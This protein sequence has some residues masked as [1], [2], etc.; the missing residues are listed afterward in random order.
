MREPITS[1]RAPLVDNYIRIIQS[2]AKR[3]RQVYHENLIE[4]LS[5]WSAAT[6]V[7]PLEK[8]LEMIEEAR[9]RGTK[10]IPLLYKM[11]LVKSVSPDRLDLSLTG[12][13]SLQF[14]KSMK[15]DSVVA[16]SDEALEFVNLLKDGFK[17]YSDAEF[18][19]MNRKFEETITDAREVEV[20]KLIRAHEGSTVHET[21]RDE[22][23]RASLEAIRGMIGAGETPEIKRAIIVY[24]LKYSDPA[25]PNRHLAV[26]EIAAPLIA[27][28]PSFFKE[29]MDSA[30]VIIYHEILKALKEN[31]LLHAIRQIGKFAVLFRGDPATPY[32]REV[33]SFEKKFFLIIEQRNLWE[34]LK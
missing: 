2:L 30:A 27:K 12:N 22:E 7:E 3:G 26:A 19:R 28:N 29:I 33:D 8:L 6:P 14:L 11:S 17:R 25:S 18:V 31:N 21:E 10:K 4:P 32:F 24:L 16:R 5:R 34:R 9:T 1:I 20:E 23:A 15:D 13:I